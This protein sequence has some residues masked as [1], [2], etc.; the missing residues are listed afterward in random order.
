[1]TQWDDFKDD[2]KRDKQA[3]YDKYD[4]LLRGQ[5]RYCSTKRSTLNAFRG[6]HTC[7]GTKKK[8]NPSAL[9]VRDLFE[10]QSSYIKHLNSEQ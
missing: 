9:A 7:L 2:C 1:M 8:S 5:S 10:S 4:P 6:W 3:W